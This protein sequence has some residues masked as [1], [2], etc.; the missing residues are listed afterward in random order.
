MTKNY[1]N[2][3]IEKIMERKMKSSGAIS[4]CGP[5]F[6]GKSTTSELFCKSKYKISTKALVNYTKLNPK[7]ALYGDI[8]HLIDEWQKVPE[9]WNLVKDDLDKEYIFGKYLLTGSSTPADES[10]IEHDGSGR[11]ITVKMSTMT[12]YETKESVGKASIKELFDNEEL[13]LSDINDKHTLSDTAFYI[14]RGGWPISVL[15]GDR[16]TAL[17]ITRNYYDGLFTFD[18]SDN[19]RFRNTNCKRFI[20]YKGSIL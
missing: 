12:L 17:D 14:C 8:P 5:K 2:R 15:C 13:E 7:E 1:I 20:I 18:D 6:C 9:I 10:I 4:V 19:E 16:D 11:I 3:Y